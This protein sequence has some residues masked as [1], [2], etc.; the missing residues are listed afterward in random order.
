[1]LI[2]ILRTISQHLAQYSNDKLFTFQKINT[3]DKTTVF[4]IEKNKYD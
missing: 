2:E 4:K 3:W 1:M